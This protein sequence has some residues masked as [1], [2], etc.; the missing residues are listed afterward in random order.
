[1]Q[2]LS[3]LE[4]EYQAAKERLQAAQQE[5]LEAATDFLSARAALRQTLETL[6]PDCCEC[7]ELEYG[8]DMSINWV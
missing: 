4:T 7:G 5:K 2:C 3:A 8:T 1:M 6:W